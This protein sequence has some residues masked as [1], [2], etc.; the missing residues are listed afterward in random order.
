[1]RK[2]AIYCGAAAGNNPTYA[3]SARKL[4]K[5]MASNNI[6]LVYG[7][8]QFGLMGIIAKTVI[9]NGGHVDGIIPENLAAR[10][11]SYQAVS[12]LQVVKDMS[13]RKQLMMDMA[14]GFIALPGGPGTL[15]EISEVF[16]WSLIGDNNKP[17]VLFNTNH[18][19]DNLQNMYDHMVVEGFL[20]SQARQK[21]LFS[22]SVE[23]IAEF[24]DTY[25]PPKI[26]E[27]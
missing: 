9:E 23:Q 16:S 5:W 18:Y 26:R 25:I 3:N 7:G 27:Y 24:M 1:M 19:Y 20:T 13:I 22:D 17:C 10:G 2:I 21:L 15:E 8:G 12:N 11:A 6:G 4:G 14:D